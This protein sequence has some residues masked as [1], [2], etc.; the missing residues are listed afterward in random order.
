MRTSN[1][2]LLTIRE[3]QQ[4]FGS[5]RDI[6]VA[7]PAHL[8]TAADA[9]PSGCHMTVRATAK[10]RV[11]VVRPGHASGAKQAKEQGKGENKSRQGDEVHGVGAGRMGVLPE[12]SQDD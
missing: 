4:N 2:L 3:A 8:Y 10:V 5:K 6:A 7:L 11:L 12:H 1:D 9:R